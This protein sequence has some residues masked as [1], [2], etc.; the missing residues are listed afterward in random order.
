MANGETANQIIA[1]AK[2]VRQTLGELERQL[3]EE[4]DEIRRKTLFEGRDMTQDERDLRDERKAQLAKARK[5]FQDLVFVNLQ[6]L[7]NSDDV[8]QMQA[9]MDEINKGLGDDLAQLERIER[10]AETAA[11]IADAVAKATAKL[12]ELAARVARG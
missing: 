12:A 7:D 6:R 9:K 8:K 5:A 3:Q 10:Y 11:K 4:I 2:A 1:D